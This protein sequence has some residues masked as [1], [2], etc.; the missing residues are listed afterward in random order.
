MATVVGGVGYGLYT[1]GKVRCLPGEH[2]KWLDANSHSDTS[3][4]WS[5]HLL[6]SASKP[7]RSPSTNSLRK[8]LSW[9]TN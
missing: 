3:I 8:H 7:T 1:L 4:H 6:P 5:C 9:L 2:S